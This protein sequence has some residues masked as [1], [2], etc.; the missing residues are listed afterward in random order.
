MALV[1]DDPRTTLFA[2]SVDRLKSKDVPPL[3][4]VTA[5]GAEVVVL[6]DVSL[7]TAVRLCDP[8]EAVV[9]FHV[10]EY[11]AD[12]SSEPREAPSSLNCTP[13]TPALS[14]AVA[15]T[16][17]ELPDRLE[18]PAGVLRLTVGAVASAAGALGAAWY[19]CSTSCALSAY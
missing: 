12:V 6:F 16:V 11:G 5:T 15:E 14:D 7:A 18:P 8:F 2:P 13:A 1:T 4:T 17:T 19:S 10:T 3:D 9:V